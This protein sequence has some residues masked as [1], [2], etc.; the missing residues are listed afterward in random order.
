MQAGIT[1]KD[2]C[3]CPATVSLSAGVPLL[4]GTCRI[5]V[6][7]IDLKISAARCGGEPE[8]TDPYLICPGVDFA[9]ITSSLIE[10]ADTGGLV[11]RMNGVDAISVIGE[12]P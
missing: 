5:S 10:L 6:A 2:I 3:T 11:T 1:E 9:S 4:Y 7:V 12:N 8:P